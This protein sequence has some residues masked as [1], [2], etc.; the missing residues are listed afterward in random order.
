MAKLRD[1]MLGQGVLRDT[2]DAAAKTGRQ[3][4]SAPRLHALL[5]WVT[6]LTLVS[7]VSSAVPPK[8]LTKLPNNLNEYFQPFI[9]NT[10]SYDSN[11]YRAPNDPPI[12]D[13]T[14]DRGGATACYLPPGASKSD[15]INQLSIGSKILV[16][17]SRQLWTLNLLGANNSFV[18]NS[19]LDNLSWDTNTAF[20]LEWAD[21]WSAKVGARYA[22]QLGGF[23]NFRFPGKDLLRFINYFGNVTYR[24]SPR[25]RVTAGGDWNEVTHSLQRRQNQDVENTTARIETVYATPL[26][27]SFGLEYTRLEGKYPGRGAEV[28]NGFTRT[29]QDKP[30]LVTRYRISEKLTFD[31]NV[32]YLW[33]NF[34]NADRDFSGEVWRLGMTWLP[35][36]KTGLTVAGYHTLG[37]YFEEQGLFYMAEGVLIEPSWYPTDKTLISATLNYETRDYPRS[38]INRQNEI[39][40]PDRHDNAFSARVAATYT[41]V[42]YADF[43]LIYEYGRR[44][45]NG[46]IIDS[47]FFQ[48]NFDSVSAIARLY[49]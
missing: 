9:W 12:V 34:D 21:S 31:G 39:V 41:P 14:C 45:A 38:G 24:I 26:G 47:Q 49:F 11:V 27:N 35:T 17:F 19:S 8:T 28:V 23:G 36:I 30:L 2:A 15:F 3:G 37:T 13:P 22:R 6:A 46:G 33:R 40:A 44:G 10:F 32:G 7:P 1:L 29:S 25:L 48:Y 4:G 43:S 18:R 20:D 5:L 42:D 16:P